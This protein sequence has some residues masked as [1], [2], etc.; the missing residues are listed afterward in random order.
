M[1]LIQDLQQPLDKMLKQLMLPTFA[2]DY[3]LLAETPHTTL[4]YLHE[5]TRREIE[6][7]YQKRIER[8]LS[9]AK[10][11]RNKL[12]KDFDSTRIPGLSTVT[13]ERLSEGEFIDRYEN[14][15]IFGNP[16]TGKTH[17]SIGLARE[18]CLLGR[19]VYF[20]TAAS[21]VQQ[22]LQAKANL[23]LNQFIK[24]MD[25]FEVLLIDDISYVPYERHETDV[26]FTLLAARYET[27]SVLI[28]SNCPFAQW[29]NIFKDEMT[30][31]ATVDR[32]VHHATI[33]E[34]N[35]ESYRMES[36]KKQSSQPPPLKKENAKMTT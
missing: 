7:R 13:L 14:I 34:L 18:W 21:L 20:I 1:S 26:L 12:L 15:L 16:G 31:A 36:A 28:T 17:L 23:K 9:Q 33:L 5:L 22:L 29:N 27:R 24:R 10:L 8:F 11:P 6:C 2:S 32:L 35:A 3:Q 4:D 19:R 25:G 30:T